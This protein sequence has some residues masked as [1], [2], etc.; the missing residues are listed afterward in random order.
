M[1]TADAVIVGAGPNGLV[2]AN[3]LADAGWDV[4]VLEATPTPGGGVRTDELIE[5]GFRNDLCSA[6]YPLAAASPV[7]RALDLERYGLRW[8][9]APDVLAHVLPDDRCAVLSRDPERTAESLESFAHGDGN[10]W[11]EEFAGWQRVRDEL[12][13][14]LFTPFPPVRH[15][16]RLLRRLGTAG[17]LRF[18][19]LTTMTSRVFGDHRF[20]GMGA[21]SLLA[22]NAFHADL[23]PAHA[24]GA[25]FGWLMCM[26][27]QDVGFPAPSGGAG[28][29]T[30]ALLRRL[31]DRGGRVCCGREAGR[32]LV[33]GRRAVGVADTSGQL[34]RAR[35]AVLAAVPAPT[36][37]LKMLD[38]GELPTGLL[39]EIARF[40]WDDATVKVDWNLSGPILWVNPAAASAG[41]LHLDLDL[42]GLTDYSADLATGRIPARPFLIAGQMTTTDPLRSPPGTETAWAYT[43]VS[44]GIHWTNDELRR[45]AD[46]IEEIIERHAP[47]F[48]G[49][50]RGRAVHGPGDLE[51]HNPNLVEGAINGGSAAMHQELVFRPIPGLGR[52]DTP[53]DRLYLA[54]AS[55]HP[56]GAVHGGPGANA[57]RAA[58]ARDGLGGGLYRRV[59]QG[60]HRLLYGQP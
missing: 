13:G 19:R 37:Y 35:R 30:A 42:T 6:F 12:L 58:L 24:G 57:A 3:L 59:M 14:A 21:K 7:M 60:S 31:A 41:T 26:L 11:R 55:A 54:S 56:G 20:S 49:R 17:T 29:L 2:A 34:V 38:R 4:L 52:A 16:A 25:V 8:S 22:G 50:V 9:H 48:R 39:D 45:F 18:A 1:E 46:R 27:G 51:R 40:R 33:A 10:A 43:H 47:G 23:G 28:E 44:R 53:I 36:L 32:V 15:G 5:P